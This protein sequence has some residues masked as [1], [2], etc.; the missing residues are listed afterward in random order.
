M[1]LKDIDKYFEA[2]KKRKKNDDFEKNL[3]TARICCVIANVNRNPK[4][5][6]TP[7]KEK[8]FMP[9]EKK[10]MSTNQFATMLKAMTIGLGG[11]I[12]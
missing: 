1:T 11:E 8:D 10:K 6:S 9:G 4:T 3:R 2:Y 7:F 5:K 12:K